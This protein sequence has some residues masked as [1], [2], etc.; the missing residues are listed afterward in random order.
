MAHLLHLKTFPPSILNMLS[1][2]QVLA[3]TVAFASSALAQS[4]VP[5][6]VLVATDEVSAKEFTVWSE[7]DLAKYAGTYSGDV[8]GDSAGK[9]I[10]KVGK[11]KKDEFPV[12]SSG[13]FSLTAAGSTPT[14]V[15]FQNATYWGDTPGLVSVGAFN[16]VFVKYGK[17]S[18][19]I[20]GNV[21]IPRE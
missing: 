14:V 16:L 9:L 7:T 18:G 10:F 11:A 19:V 6:K 2:I 8:G 5:A 13:T 17:T 12:L 3:L 21:F 20:V 1:S 4:P 15:S